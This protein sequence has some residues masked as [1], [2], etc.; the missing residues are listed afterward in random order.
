MRSDNEVAAILERMERDY[1]GY[2][3]GGPLV[4]Q[5]QQRDAELY[6]ALHGPRETAE[7]DV[8]VAVG[9][10]ASG[11]AIVRSGRVEVWVGREMLYCHGGPERQR[12]SPD[13]K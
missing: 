8:L 1:G 2:F 10:V 12:V 6:T 4:T 7:P 3:D 9:D 11:C 13:P 5:E